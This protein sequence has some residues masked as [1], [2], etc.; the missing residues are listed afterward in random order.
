[1]KILT[2]I[3]E[4]LLNEAGFPVI[5][6]INVRTDLAFPLRDIGKTAQIRRLIGC[7]SECTE[8]IFFPKE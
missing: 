6:F 4:K 8:L 1:M 7:S 2:K 3:W 5:P